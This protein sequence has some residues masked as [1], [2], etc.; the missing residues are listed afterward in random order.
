MINEYPA[1]PLGEDLSDQEP[2]APQGLPI[3]VT[4]VEVGHWDANQRNAGN[5]QRFVMEISDQRV[6]EGKAH[7]TLAAWEG[8]LDDMMSVAL[9]VASHP[10]SG[11]CTQAAV[12]HVGDH[13]LVTLFKQRDE[14]LLVASGPDV[15]VA[16]APLTHGETVWLIS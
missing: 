15:R 1:P 12:V 4:Q 11:E 8:Q 6:P 2:L 14:V 10:Q 7:V 5:R 3:G 16:P 9:E 13:H